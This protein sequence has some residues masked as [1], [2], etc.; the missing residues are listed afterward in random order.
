MTFTSGDTTK[1]SGAA[2]II[3]NNTQCCKG[4]SRQLYASTSQPK[5]SKREAVGFVSVLES[6]SKLQAWTSGGITGTMEELN[7]K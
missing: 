1:S 7:Q 2:T 5:L 4:F 6:S 3:H